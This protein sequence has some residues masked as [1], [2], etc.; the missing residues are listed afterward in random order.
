MSLLTGFNCTSQIKFNNYIIINDN[1]YS[2]NDYNND[3]NL[4]NDN[5]KNKNV[6]TITDLIYKNVLLRINCALE[7]LFDY[8]YFNLSTIMNNY[9]FPVILV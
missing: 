5:V 8:V 1:D 6:I 7:G 3:K 2:Y 9:S 4:D